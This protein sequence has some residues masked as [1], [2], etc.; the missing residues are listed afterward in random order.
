MEEIH[1]LPAKISSS[2][3]TDSKGISRPTALPGITRLDTNT[4]R[5]QKKKPVVVTNSPEDVCTPQCV[6]ATRSV[7]TPQPLIESNIKKVSLKRTDSVICIDD[8]SIEEVE[9]V[10][11]VV[12][13][14][15]KASSSLSVPTI[16]KNVEPNMTAVEEFANLELS[17]SDED[18]EPKET[19]EASIAKKRRFLQGEIEHIQWPE[20]PE[21]TEDE[22][23]ETE[24]SEN[25]EAKLD[26]EKAE[27]DLLGPFFLK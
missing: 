4:P 6:Q 11:T 7:G 5:I 25:E 22:P 21:E 20:E 26:E 2:L 14:A 10:Q 13:E 17:S 16:E 15:N 12:K 24:D 8:D 18:E 19:F 3:S 9:T 23:I 1:P 27:V